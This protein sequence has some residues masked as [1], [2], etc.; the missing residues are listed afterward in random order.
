M[1]ALKK[2]DFIPVPVGAN[3]TFHRLVW[4]NS[5]KAESIRAGSNL[6]FHTLVD[7]STAR[8][9]STPRQNIFRKM[10][11]KVVVSNHPIQFDSLSVRAQL[12]SLEPGHDKSVAVNHQ[13]KTK[14]GAR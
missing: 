4:E 8:R 5:G 2:D 1:I 13:E 3:I 9:K 12:S 6:R 14:R 7:D 10:P 11:L